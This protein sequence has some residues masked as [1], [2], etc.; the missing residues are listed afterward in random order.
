MD[1]NWKSRIGSEQHR[2]FIEGIR[3]GR[4][5][6]ITFACCCA[7]VGGMLCFVPRSELGFMVQIGIGGVIVSSFLSLWVFLKQQ[8][9]KD[10]GHRILRAIDEKNRQDPKQTH[11]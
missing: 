9:L 4:T 3:P 11:T 1:Q 2:K 6:L 7:A 10:K 8:A 5:A